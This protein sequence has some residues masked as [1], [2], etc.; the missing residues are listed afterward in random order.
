[1]LVPEDDAP[2][3]WLL[4]VAE[5]PHTDFAK[6]GHESAEPPPLMSASEMLSDAAQQQ[7]QT[8]Q[9][10]WDEGALTEPATRP[11]GWEIPAAQPLI[12]E[13]DHRIVVHT[14]EGHVKRGVTTDIDLSAEVISLAPAVGQPPSDI[15]SMAQTKALFFL[16]EPGD[17][18]PAPPPNAQRVRV[19]FVD[20]RQVEGYM[21]E[22]TG[23][24]FFLFPVDNR[25]KNAKMFVF[26][27]AV[28]SMN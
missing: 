4:P 24:G 1:M 19:T 8:Q 10:S 25:T 9:Q 21:G 26:H 6:T 14:L 2:Q 15:L 27:H 12:I 22:D 17:V 7:W 11:V 5:E 13:G 20:N 3:D 16:L 28:S 18:A 23:N